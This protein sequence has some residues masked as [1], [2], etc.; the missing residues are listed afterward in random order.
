MYF[1]WL[2]LQR[3]RDAGWRNFVHRT[4]S[5]YRASLGIGLGV[6]GLWGLASTFNTFGCRDRSG[7]RALHALSRANSKA[8]IVLASGGRVFL[9]DHQIVEVL[10]RIAFFIHKI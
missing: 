7:H 4:V 3:P 6:A 10:V 9:F 5:I 1:W 2:L 8:T